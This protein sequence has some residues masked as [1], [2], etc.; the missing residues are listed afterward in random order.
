MHISAKR[1]FYT[2]CVSHPISLFTV[3]IMSVFGLD[4]QYF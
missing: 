3:A 4:L 1:P 2:K